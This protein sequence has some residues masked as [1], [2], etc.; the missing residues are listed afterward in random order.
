MTNQNSKLQGRKRGNM[1]ETDNDSQGKKSRIPKLIIAV[2]VLIAA[3][4]VLKLIRTDTAAFLVVVLGGGWILMK[5]DER[6]RSVRGPRP[7]IS[8]FAIASVSISFTVFVGWHCLV[9]LNRNRSFDNVAPYLVIIV[10][11]ATLLLPVALIM[12]IYALISIKKSEGLLKGYVF[13][14]LGILMSFLAFWYGFMRG[15]VNIREEASIRLSESAMMQIGQ[16]MYAY[17]T[18]YENKYPIADKWCDLFVE[19]IDVN[20]VEFVC[21]VLRQE[22]CYYAI[23]PKCEP[24]SPGDIVLL[25]ET[26]WGWNQFG[27]SEVA[28]LEKHHRKG[29][30]VLFNDGHVEFVSPERF[31]ELK[32]GEDEMSNVGQGNLIKK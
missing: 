21:Q 12:G 28:T 15:W 16:V 3:A 24:N 20:R 11:P 7:K 4:F 25:F 2:L 8:V 13:S 29:C 5:M 26:Q 10:V 6:D 1:G 32:W 22:E 27:G 19:Y 17:S 14:T 31:G 18:D 30:N 23:N 9:L